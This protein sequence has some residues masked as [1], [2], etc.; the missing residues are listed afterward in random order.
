MSEHNFGG[1]GNGVIDVL[2]GQL[3]RGG[4]GFTNN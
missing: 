1:T 3:I 2:D 4:K